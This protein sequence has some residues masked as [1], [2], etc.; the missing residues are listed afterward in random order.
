ML[1]RPQGTY[2]RELE[3][4]SLLASKLM[5]LFANESYLSTIKSYLL[6]L[7]APVAVVHGSRW[8][9]GWQLR[10]SNKV[11]FLFQLSLIETSW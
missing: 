11:A 6:S 9:S 3:L 1:R 7:A 10:G 4:S 5:L 8:V 2:Q